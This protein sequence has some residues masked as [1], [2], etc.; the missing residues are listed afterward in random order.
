MVISCITLELQRKKKKETA[1]LIFK[2]ASINIK[3][4]S[5]LKWQEFL[6]SVIYKGIFII[7]ISGK[8]VWAV[9]EAHCKCNCKH[10]VEKHKDKLFICIFI[11]VFLQLLIVE[12][13]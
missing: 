13:K 5:S 3:K 1:V 7:F 6:K 10:P 12:M 4:Y 11:C 2:I 9:L 8:A